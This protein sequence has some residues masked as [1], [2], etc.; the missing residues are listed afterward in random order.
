MA[1]KHAGRRR[2]NRT[3]IF[4]LTDTAVTFEL[5][6]RIW[7][8][9]DALSL[10]VAEVISA[11]VYNRQDWQNPLMA[12][13]PYFANVTR[14]GIRLTEARAAY[15]AYRLIRAREALQEAAVMWEM[16]HFNTYIN[17]LYY[18]CFYAVSALLLPEG[19]SAARHV[20]IRNLFS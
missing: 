10:E 12:V 1:H 20:G 2:G 15:L 7:H 19:L 17:R 11:M 4:V 18:A 8:R 14:E 6:R 9:L 3:G 5:E 16:A 13:T